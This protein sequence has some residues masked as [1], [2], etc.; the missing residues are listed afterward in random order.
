MRLISFA[1]TTEQFYK[2][3]KDVTRRLGWL[4]LKPGQ[5]LC[6]AEK[7]QGLRPG[8]ALKRLAIIR[9]KSARREPLSAITPDDVAREGFPGMSTSEFIEMFCQSHE[10]C[11]PS[12]IVTRIEFQ[13]IP[14]GRFPYQRS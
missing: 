4:H 11:V 10:S 9:V 8:E 13:F 14:G 3:K 6:G 7:C 2:R 1:L 12:S 5:L